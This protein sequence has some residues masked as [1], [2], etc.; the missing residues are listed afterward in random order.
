M[1][2]HTI[3]GLFVAMFAIAAL[4]PSV[5][6]Q[7]A[8]EDISVNGV[9]FLENGA[10]LGSTLGVSAGEVIPVWV[11]FTGTGAAGDVNE[12]V[13][14]VARIRG[15]PGFSA[16]SERFEV[17]GGSTYSRLFNVQLPYDL[18]EDL[19]DNFVLE[20]TLENNN[21]GEL[22]SYDAAMRI[23]RS[24]YELEILAVEADDR[25]QAGDNLA[26]DVVVKN[27]GRQEALDTF[28][29]ASIPEAGIS[30][31]LF[32][33]DIAEQDPV[34]DEADNEYDSEAGRIFL[35][36]PKDVPAGVYTLEVEA[37]TDDSTTVVT[38]K[39]VVLGA[40]EES[41]VVTSTTSKTFAAGEEQAYTLT[42]VNAG[43]QIKVYDLILESADGLTINF[44]E[45][46]IAVP[47]GSSRTVQFVAS[48]PEN[49]NYDFA[50]NVHSDGE[51][52]KTQ[53]YMANVEGRSSVAGDSA[54][55]LT[56]VL[57][58]IFVVLLVVLIVLLTRKPEKNEEFGE[59]YY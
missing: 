37:F 1:K 22:D 36:V 40:S 47:A 56:V 54:V 21:D 57:A 7:A 5:S 58:I 44:D 48:A 32:L 8:F 53:N 20:I 14:L 52:V 18:D 35:R 31:M 12:D 50:V 39:V 29:R 27:R 17:L 33:G 41:A 25:V 34:G 2:K 19:D 38:R 30:K 59:S 9:D 10:N 13:R 46:V 3:F 42:V 16:V 55:L 23:Q 26:V 28:I 11:T 45:S 4:V 49:G 51:L 6:A 43:N 24:S 15:E